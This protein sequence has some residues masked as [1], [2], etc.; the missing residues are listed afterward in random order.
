MLSWKAVTG[1]QELSG[2]DLLFLSALKS[3]IVLHTGLFVIRFFHFVLFCLIIRKSFDCVNTLCKINFCNIDVRIFHS[4]LFFACNTNNLYY[5]VTRL[6]SLVHI[7]NTIK[8]QTIYKLHFTS[9]MHAGHIELAH[10]L[11]F[12]H[13]FFDNSLL[14]HPHLHTSWNKFSFS[15]ASYRFKSVYTILG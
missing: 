1:L 13:L 3:Y 4:I 6:N 2:H 14:K 8:Q 10:F 9:Y 11:C 12:P 15:P 7:Y 5:L